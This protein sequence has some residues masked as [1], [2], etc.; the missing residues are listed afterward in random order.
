MLQKNGIVEANKKHIFHIP[1][2]FFY[3]K[4]QISKK[5][6]RG[7]AKSKGNIKRYKGGGSDKDGDT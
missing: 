1:P 3:L 4:K 6:S 7:G 2:G 5:V